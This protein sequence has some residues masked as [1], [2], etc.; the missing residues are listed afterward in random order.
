MSHSER[1]MY[2]QLIFI[3]LNIYERANAVVG[4]FSADLVIYFFMFEPI[5]LP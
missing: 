4:F 3:L 2:V 1:N 5:F